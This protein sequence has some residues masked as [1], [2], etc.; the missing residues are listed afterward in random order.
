MIPY[1]LTVEVSNDEN[2]FLQLYLQLSSLLI[3]AWYL[4]TE[5]IK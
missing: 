2:I 1:F 3:F 5:K 4:F